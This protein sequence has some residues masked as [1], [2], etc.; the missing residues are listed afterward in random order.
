MTFP[1]AVL[2]CTLA[3]TTSVRDSVWDAVDEVENRRK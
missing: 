2:A 1:T 3:I